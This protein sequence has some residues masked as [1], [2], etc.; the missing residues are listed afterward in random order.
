[1]SPRGGRSMTKGSTGER[2]TMLFGNFFDDFLGN[3]CLL[4]IV[5]VWAIGWVI[6]KIAQNEDVQ[7]AAS[8]S[9]WRWFFK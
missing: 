4:F 6:S 8:D 3:A 9:F 7:N 1:M 5:I 2:A